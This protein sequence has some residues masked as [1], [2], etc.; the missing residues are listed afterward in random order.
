MNKEKAHPRT[1][2]IAQLVNEFNYPE[3][4]IREIARSVN[5]HENPDAGYNSPYRLTLEEVRHRLGY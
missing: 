2:R 1:Y 4:R 3:A 5:R